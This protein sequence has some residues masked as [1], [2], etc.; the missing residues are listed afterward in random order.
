MEENMEN[1]IDLNNI[2]ESLNKIMNGKTEF[3]FDEKNNSINEI[4]LLA[5][6]YNKNSN[7]IREFSKSVVTLA[8]SLSA[9]DLKL[10]YSS[11]IIKNNTNELKIISNDFNDQF[12]LINNNQ[13]DLLTC[14]KNISELVEKVVSEVLDVET[15]DANN[16]KLISNIVEQINSIKL[17]SLNLTKQIAFL[18]DASSRIN[19]TIKDLGRITVQTRMLAINASIEAARAGVAGRGFS[20]VAQELQNL[21]KNTSK[22]LSNMSESIENI[23]NSIKLSTLSTDDNTISIETIST[24]IDILNT[25][26]TNTSSNIFNISSEISAIN[27]F[28]HTFLANTDTTSQAITKGLVKIDN[29]FH[30][31]NKLAMVSNDLDEIENA[32]HNVEVL[33]S[34]SE[35][36][37]K[38]ISTTPQYKFKNGDFIAILESAIDGH[39]GWMK[40]VEKMVSNN[41]IIPVQSD[42][43]KC[44]FGHYYYLLT[45]KHTEIL[46][47]WK[48]V[49]KV[50]VDMHLTGDKI[51]YE[52]ANNNQEKARFYC[53]E[54]SNY[55]STIVLLFK[56]MIE[57]TKNLKNEDI[58]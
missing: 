54:A 52:I 51:I 22:L 14:S 46:P 41:Y 6:L 28:T 31:V 24:T 4:K 8:S 23:N 26:L 18:S 5:T 25:N 2:K 7:E 17:K 39:I 27:K 57:I 32:F 30:L 44:G 16:T 40:T 36:L 35:S 37:I 49:E 43:H 45:P 42:A 20:V 33:A 50:H 11:K 1:N 9:F 3:I 38:T 47:I 34:K 58:L 12:L 15:L 19:E 13:L 10:N 21:S 29:I 55:S 56:K 48:S 53:N